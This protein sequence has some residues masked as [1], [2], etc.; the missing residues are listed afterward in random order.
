MI[1]NSCF[2]RILRKALLLITGLI[3]ILPIQSFAEGTIKSVTGS[4]LIKR[5][6]E[7]W[8]PLKEGDA[9]TDGAVLWISASSSLVL[10]VGDKLIELSGG[11]VGSNMLINKVEPFDAAIKGVGIRYLGAQLPPA[12]PP[13]LLSPPEGYRSANGAIELLWS[14]L[15]KEV[16]Y[17]IQISDTPDFNKLVLDEKGYSAEKK[18]IAKLG[19]G[20]FYWRVSSIDKD[21]LEGGFSA[22]WSFEVKPLPEPPS[23]GSPASTKTS[24]TV[25]WKRRSEE[26]RYHLQI[27]KNKDFSETDVDLKDIEGPRVTVGTLEEGDYFVRVSA[28][29]EDGLEG[30]FSEP[31]SF[32]VGPKVPSSNIGPLMIMFGVAFML[33]GIP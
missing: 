26:E 31:Q 32:Y 23:V 25:R 11:P 9:I 13:L 33:L 20:K 21:G 17:H 27:S 18:I 6:G 30:R 7:E 12:P 2:R 15:Q 8:Q 22:T 3:F 29:D 4:S 16:L 19:K 14:S 24:T 10:K 28:I 1:T 5:G